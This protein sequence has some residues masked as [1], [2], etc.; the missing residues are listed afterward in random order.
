MRKRTPFIRFAPPDKPPSALERLFGVIMSILITIFSLIL[1]YSGAY[2]MML[3]LPQ[4][5]KSIERE[6]SYIDS[7]AS[8][9]FRKKRPGGAYI[10][11]RS[12]ADTYYM[13]P[14]LITTPFESTLRKA[15]RAKLIYQTKRMNRDGK[16]FYTLVG[17]TLDGNTHLSPASYFIERMLQGL[18]MLGMG[19]VGMVMMYHVGRDLLRRKS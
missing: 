14:M 2:C 9:G 3:A 1:I 10:H 18:F 5:T 8:A 12:D 7:G 15:K 19:G 4:P 6:I 17:I 11:L 13:E 16:S